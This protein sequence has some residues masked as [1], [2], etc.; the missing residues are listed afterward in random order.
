MMQRTSHLSTAVWLNNRSAALME[1]GKFESAVTNLSTG[2]E[3]SRQ[4]WES[5]V[6]KQISSTPLQ[7]SLDECMVHNKAQHHHSMDND[8]QCFES[9]YYTLSNEFLYQRPIPIP[10][11][12]I[13]SSKD[14]CATISAAIIFNLAL[15]LQLLSV[16]GSNN[17][18]DYRSHLQKAASLYELAFSL[19]RDELSS[20]NPR[21]MLAIINNLGMVYLSLDEKDKARNL[22]QQLESILMFLI[23]NGDSGVISGCE[24]FFRNT[25]Q[26]SS[27]SCSAPAA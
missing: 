20:M 7:T 3:V 11:G 8:D 14:S 2:L 1:M 25:S 26:F 12:S 15:S 4:L 24:C 22:F 9:E 21:F 5:I 23:D 18:V 6:R 17:I 16:R 13:G 10:E 19:Q 27:L